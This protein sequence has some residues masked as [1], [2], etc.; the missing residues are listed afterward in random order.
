MS[1]SLLARCGLALAAAAL[2]VGGLATPAQAFAQASFHTLSTGNRGVDVR[3][4]QYLL[5]ARNISVT[6]DGIFG[7]S[8]AAAVRSFQ[9]SA[10]LSQDGVV[11]AQTWGALVLTVREGSTGPAVRAVQVQLNK[12]RRLG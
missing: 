8:T 2:A 6:A 7:S 9:A 12:K 4:V 5:Q 10:G 3:A 11:G 1:R